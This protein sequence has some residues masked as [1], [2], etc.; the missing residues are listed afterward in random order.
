MKN[1]RYGDPH[2]G[3]T[4]AMAVPS[5][6]VAGEV[7]TIG[8]GLR[9]IALTDRATSATIADGTAAP[10]LADGEASVRL[11]GV[12]WVV[13]LAIDGGAAAVGEKIYLVA[14]TPNTYSS[15]ATGNSLIGYSL[16]VVGDGDEGLVALLPVA[17]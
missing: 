1:L 8:E 6:T 9:V 2:S 7:L 11:I 3:V 12:D 14:A 13:S 15:T 16:E 17:S 4:L 10:G 5:G